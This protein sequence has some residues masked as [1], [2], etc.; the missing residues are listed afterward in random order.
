[1]IALKSTRTEIQVLN[2]KDIVA[3]GDDT[4]F[5]TV[6]TTELFISVLVAPKNILFNFFCCLL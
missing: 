3:N 4:D 1:M 6:I 5:I 2:V